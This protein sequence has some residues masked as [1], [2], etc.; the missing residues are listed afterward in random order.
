M[1]PS[2]DVG[3]ALTAKIMKENGQ[4]VHRSTKRA[5]MHDKWES[6]VEKPHV[7]SLI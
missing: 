1:A 6:Y 5:L 7:I 4:V 2:I 3:L